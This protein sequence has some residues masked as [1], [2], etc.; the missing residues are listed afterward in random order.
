MQQK[1]QTLHKY[2]ISGSETLI[3]FSIKYMNK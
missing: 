3:V 2:K 1:R